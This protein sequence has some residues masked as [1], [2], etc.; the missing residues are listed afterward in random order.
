MTTLRLVSA[1]DVRAESAE[2]RGPTWRLEA[3]VALRAADAVRAAAL[4]LPSDSTLR[5]CLLD[6]AT[7]WGLLATLR[8]LRPIEGGG[9]CADAAAWAMVADAAAEGV[10]LPGLTPASRADLLEVLEGARG[11]AGLGVRV[12]ALS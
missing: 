4:T 12:A 10:K 1:G 3:E 7:D 6:Q 11:A 5:P 8:G 9:M 2:T